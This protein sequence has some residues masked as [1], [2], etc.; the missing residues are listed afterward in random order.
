MKIVYAFDFDGT[1]TTK[2]T[3]LEFIKY[4]VGSKRFILGF[5]LFAPMMVLMKCHLMKNYKVKQYFFS[6]FFKGMPLDEFN[7][8]CKKFTQNKQN[9][10]RPEALKYL[11]IASK[12]GEVIILSASV[13]NWIRPFFREINL[14]VIG[15]QLE[16]DLSKKLT[17]KFATKNCYGSEKVNRLLAL[18][19]KRKM[20]KLVAFGDSY[21]DKELLAFADESHYK[22]FRQ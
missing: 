6:W 14:V 11:T 9:I 15:T 7:V 4:V 3:L 20:Y 8:W 18:Y 5:I 19:P 21:G 1:L 13:E 2:D 17:G 22:P 16:V 10:L 12:S